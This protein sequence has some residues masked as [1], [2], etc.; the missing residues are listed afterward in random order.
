MQWQESLKIGDVIDAVLTENWSKRSYSWEKAK[1]TGIFS[2]AVSVKFVLE[3]FNNMLFF[4]VYF[5]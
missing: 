5:L 4:F 3:E 1:I 2:S